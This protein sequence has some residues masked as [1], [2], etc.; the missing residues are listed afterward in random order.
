MATDFWTSEKTA[1]LKRLAGTDLSASQIGAELG[2]TRNAV[3]G[4]LERLGLKSMSAKLC[5]A[6]VEANKVKQKAV[7]ERREERRRL[8]ERKA[9]LARE[10]QLRKAA[11][12]MAPRPVVSQPEPKN[13][14][15]VDLDHDACRF[16]TAREPDEDG[17]WLFCGAPCWNNG[18]YCAF[19]AGLTY[20]PTPQPHRKSDRDKVRSIKEL[21]AE[22]GPGPSIFRSIGE[23]A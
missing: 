20:T 2:C 7:Q 4:K 1:E 22:F 23:A 8:Q 11:I 14:P 10:I 17:R 16:S 13:L 18:A 6:R 12:E 21:T 19:H 9:A 15:L 3:L 5:V